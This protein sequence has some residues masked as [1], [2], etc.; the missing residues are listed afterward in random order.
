[1]HSGC[2]GQYLRNREDMKS[3]AITASESLDE[4]TPFTLKKIFSI[5][6]LAHV[7]I[8]IILPLLFQRNIALDMAEGLAWGKE[9]QLG[10]EKDP[11][12]FPWVI[13]TITSWSNRGIWISYLA[14][15][16]CVA[17]VFFAVW[18]LGRRVA[19]EMQAL[20]GALLLEGIYYLSLPVLELNDI[21][22]QMPF[23]ALF[24][25]FLHK[26]IQDN[27]LRYWM[28]AGLVSSLG[29][30]SRY[31]MGA[32]IVPIAIFV[33]IHPTSRGRL[34]SKGPWLLILISALVFFPHLCWI[35]ESDFISIK[36]VGNRAP[37]ISHAF[38]F[39]KEYFSFIGA[40]FLA[41][42]PM[43]LVASFLWRWRSS[44]IWLR[45]RW[46]DFDF[47]YIAVLALGPAIFSLLLSLLAQRPLRAMWGAP[48][49]FFIGIFIVIIFQP[50][51]TKKRFRH[52]IR[53]WIVLLIFPASFFVAEKI[54]GT[55][56]TGNEQAV[57][58]PGENFGNSINNRWSAMTKKPL[59]YVVGSTWNA[60]N[61]AFYAKDRPSVI[62]SHADLHVSPWAKAEEIKRAGAVI[63]WNMRE[64]GFALPH[65]LASR[66]P[67]AI[68]QPAVTVKGKRYHHFGVAYILPQ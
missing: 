43:L 15:Q 21:V 54:Y 64:E 36:Y 42:L 26:A 20:V 1:M 63:V 25:W 30:L 31:S 50:I 45:A 29:L 19:T 23:S 68:V 9:W 24:A 11:P 5:A 59:K 44:R 27:Q 62:F 46:N 53:A 56:I 10:Y 52:F 37:E 8:W 12:L 34:R 4:T 28:L 57:N 48:L 66:F 33:L 22:L 35:I 55:D 41:L 32:Y 16:L 39:I 14:G 40:Q 6:V 65:Y 7:T 38:T 17:T 67:D 49:W 47:C 13:Q 3:E 51:L 61:V 58:F 18:Q 2:T 60:G